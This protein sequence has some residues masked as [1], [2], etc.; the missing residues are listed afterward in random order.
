LKIYKIKTYKGREDK[1]HY[2]DIYYILVSKV[3][4]EEIEGFELSKHLK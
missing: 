4:R 1:L 3:F 2:K